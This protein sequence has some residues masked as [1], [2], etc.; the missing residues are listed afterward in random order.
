M[1]R[2]LDTLPA[3]SR[4]AL[5]GAAGSGFTLAASGLLLPEWL[6]AE[7]E[8]VDLPVRRVQHRA[9]K[10]RQRRR[11]HHSHDAN[12]PRKGHPNNHNP[13]AFVSVMLSGSQAIPSNTTTTIR[14]D[15]ILSQ[16]GPGRFDLATSR[17][18]A[19]LSGVYSV[20]VS[21]IWSGSV[22]GRRETGLA[23]TDS[24]Y[25]PGDIGMLSTVPTS[26]S[27]STFVRLE[28]GDS[29]AVVGL[30]DSAAQAQVSAGTMSIILQTSD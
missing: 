13:K 2:E 19:E 18:T 6:I 9:D 4:R 14:F 3:W 5:L 7:T 22:V 30:Q 12:G 29:L 8:A 28:L 24:L 21:V 16:G 20:N 23:G 27:F 17:F 11:D 26:A 10:R 15:V 1:A 25:I